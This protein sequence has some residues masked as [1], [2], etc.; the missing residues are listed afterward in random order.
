MAPRGLG[1]GPGQ[2]LGDGLQF[3]LLE[4]TVWPLHPAGRMAVPAA[5]HVLH[6]RLGP[7]GPM[8]PGWVCRPGRTARAAVRAQSPL[9][10]APVM[11]TSLHFLDE[12]SKARG[13][14]RTCS[15][16]HRWKWRSPDAKWHLSDSKAQ[17]LTRSPSWVGAGAGGRQ[18][19]KVPPASPG[20]LEL[21]PPAIAA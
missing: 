21:G 8:R 1:L 20:L 14:D 3:L 12:G 5:A 18:A 4:A 10:P 6:P 7:T 9:Q 2:H 15:R 13:G 11:G 16:S 17:V 19:C